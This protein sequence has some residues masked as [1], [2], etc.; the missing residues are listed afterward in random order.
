MSKPYTYQ[1]F[2]KPTVLTDD[3]FSYVSFYYTAHNKVIKFHSRENAEKYGNP[4]QYDFK[5]YWK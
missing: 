3:V 2:T 4:K 1:E 5:F